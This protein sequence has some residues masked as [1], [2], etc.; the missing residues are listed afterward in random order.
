MSSP[1]HLL[2]VYRRVIKARQSASHAVLRAITFNLLS[3]ISELSVSENPPI[4]PSALPLGAPCHR[5]RSNKANRSSPSL[6]PV[7]CLA[8]NTAIS[9]SHHRWSRGITI[10]N[11]SII[12][13]CVRFNPVGCWEKV[14]GSIIGGG[15][16]AL[17]SVCCA[18]PKHRKTKTQKAPSLLFAG[19]SRAKS[20]SQSPNPPRAHTRSRLR[21]NI[22]LVF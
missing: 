4:A 2:P 12:P 21:M 17:C 15:P 9:L 11:G 7:T 20:Q 16:R 18:T 3:I 19:D 10:S 13:S 6:R 5:R 22:L 1:S 14:K 8:P